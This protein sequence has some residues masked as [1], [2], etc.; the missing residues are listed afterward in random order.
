M[1]AAIETQTA[2]ISSVNWSEVFAKLVERRLADAHIVQILGRLRINVE[3]FTADDAR[4]AG[5]LRRWTRAAGLSF[6]D[7]ACLALGD[8]LSALVLTADQAWSR[9]ELGIAVE[10]IR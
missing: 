6:G 8:R 9:V 4:R 10:Q 5:A 3:P 1:L 7:R 2:T